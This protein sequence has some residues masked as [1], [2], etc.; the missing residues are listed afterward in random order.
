MTTLLPRGRT[1]SQQARRQRILDTALVLLDRHDVAEIQMKDV[2]EAAN[3][4]LGT[5]YRYFASKDRLFAEVLVQ[6]AGTLG[7]NITRR[8]LA[9]SSPAEKLSDALRRSVRAFQRQPQL[10]RL[11]SMLE[12]SPEPDAAETLGRLSEVTT[13]IYLDQLAGIPRQRAEAVVRVAHAVLSTVLRAWSSG[14]LPI[15][16]V[17]RRLDE[18]VHLL[19]DEARPST[20]S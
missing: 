14:L 13:A 4:A 2:A 1:A 10:A 20:R 3:V 16:E 12:V 17:N 6:W 7:T 19:L 11:V 8:P 18:T 5:L 15:G 9:G